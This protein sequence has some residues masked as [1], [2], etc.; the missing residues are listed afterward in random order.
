MV[1]LV[2]YIN[3]NLITHIHTHCF[4]RSG[5]WAVTGEDV[6]RD[7]TIIIPQY[8][9]NLNKLVVS[10]ILLLSICITTAYKQSIT[11]LIIFFLSFPHFR[12]ETL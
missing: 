8:V 6:I 1:E 2:F 4:T 9:R 5:T 3:L 10:I 7:G 12:K 11:I